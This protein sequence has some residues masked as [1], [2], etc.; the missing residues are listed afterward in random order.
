MAGYG[1]PPYQ[2][3][4][5]CLIYNVRIAKVVMVGLERKGAE[6]KTFQRKN[7]MDLRLIVG[8]GWKKTARARSYCLTN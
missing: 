8:V 1:G 7:M 5:Q 2:E 3:A 6:W 4:M